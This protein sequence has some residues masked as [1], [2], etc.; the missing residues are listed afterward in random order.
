MSQLQQHPLSAAF[1][2]MPAAELDALAEDIKLHGQH[3]PGV[4][5]EDKVLDGWH[6]Y[7]ACE[8]AGVEFKTYRLNGEDPV[9]FVIS[10]NEKRRH[11]TASQRAYSVAKCQEIWRARGKSAPGALQERKTDAELAKSVGVSERTMEQAKT[12]IRAGLG[13]ELKA[14]TISAKVGDKLAKM[15]PKKREKAL[16]EIKEGKPLKPP[17]PKAVKDC[18]NCKSLEAKLADRQEALDEMA[19]IA[20]SAE[21]FRKKDEFKEMQ[22]L[23]IELRAVKQRRGELMRESAEQKKL[24]TYWKKK[25][26]KK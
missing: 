6:R 16:K 5:F 25:V 3:Q 8:R 9:A 24:I 21:A 10:A 22:N 11:E 19:D 17:K 7:L 15:P 18:A 26:E 4:L 2:S 23:R 14:G 20:A 1:N 13:D 12:T